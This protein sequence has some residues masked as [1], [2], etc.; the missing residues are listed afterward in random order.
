MATNINITPSYQSQAL[1]KTLSS[2]PEML[3]QYQRARQD[4][5]LAE[6][7]AAR[8]ERRLVIEESNHNW[9][10]KIQE[11]G[12]NAQNALNHWSGEGY[13]Y[14]LLADKDGR[15]AYGPLG[16]LPDRETK[17]QGYSDAMKSYGTSA[18]RQVFESSANLSDQAYMTAVAR[19]FRSDAVTFRNFGNNSQLSEDD[20]NRG[21][22]D[23][24]HAKNVYDNYMAVYGNQATQEFFAGIYQP[25]ADKVSKTDW[26]KGLIRKPDMT[27]PFSDT[28]T[29]GGVNMSTPV[30]GGGGGAALFGGYKTIQKH[31]KRTASE[32]LSIAEEWKKG[33]KKSLN[34][35]EFL[36]KFG[37]TK[38]EGGG[39]PNAKNAKFKASTA[40]NK[41]ASN[42]A[43]QKSLLYKGGKF[44]LPQIAAYDILSQVQ[45]KTGLG[46]NLVADIAKIGATPYVA[47]KGTEIT[48]KGVMKAL[49]NKKLQALLKRKGYQRLLN[50]AMGS[51]TVGRFGWPGKVASGLGYTLAGVKLYQL[52]N[53]DPELRKLATE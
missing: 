3:L 35:K 9:N 17:W 52:I 47:K 28:V 27:S 14:D 42:K 29:P 44:L 20:L 50:V 10:K 51:K 45:E 41:I 34:A 13:R 11:Q 5:A 37:M 15:L 16:N 33:G 25:T 53:S 6:E 21:L 43:A 31:G 12:I 26:L 19:R 36:K 24:L 8:Q 49:G 18:N 46:D 39:N 1:S 23:Q 32:L 7:S 38:T 22:Q 2:V 30:I 40:I 4:K 48:M